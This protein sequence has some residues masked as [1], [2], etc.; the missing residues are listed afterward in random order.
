[1]A[2]PSFI[3]KYQRIADLVR[4]RL[5]QGD[6]VMKPVPSE[7]NLAAEMGVSYMTIRRGLEILETEN[8]IFRQ[9]NGRIGLKP[10]HEAREAL[11][12]GGKK[13]LN[14]AFLVPTTTSQ[15]LE[16]WRWALE[17]A[18]KS[19]PCVVRPILF[20]H[21]EDPMLLDAI[22]GFDGIFLNPIP[23]AIP[24]SVAELLRHPDH[25]VV[26]VDHD[27]SGYGVPSIDLFPPASVQRLMDHLESMG[28][29]RIGCLNSQ[30]ND[31]EVQG[32]INQWR[33]WMSAHGFSGSLADFGVAASTDAAQHAYDTMS[34]ILSKGKREETAWFCTTAPTA[35]GAMA[36]MI[37]RSLQ[38]GRDI[39]ICAANGEMIAAMLNPPL[40]ALEAPDPTPFLSICLDWMSRGGRR[41]QGPLLMQP[42]EVPL[43]I[44]ES[45]KPGAGRGLFPQK[46]A[47]AHAPMNGARKHRQAAS[48]P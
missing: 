33:Y 46:T 4:E 41:W 36:A 15:A 23:E 3:P 13:H 34:G 44:R 35:M 32:R 19:L 37:D 7:R 6:Y 48:K 31:L 25:P 12:E 10:S 21:W 47:G 30:P 24:E 29:T 22:K 2:K 9:P 45:T 39:A 17:K 20:M 26:V 5:Q 18:T 42:A 27:F 8:L 14:L 40:T 16:V 1:M 11:E 43:V 38:P 28:H